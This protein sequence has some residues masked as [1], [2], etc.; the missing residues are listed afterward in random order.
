MRSLLALVFAFIPT[1]VSAADSPAVHG[2]LLFG[3]KQQY[4]SHL[5]MFHKPHDYQAVF[6][7]DLSHA[8]EY[9]ADKAAHP[10][11]IYTVVPTPFSLPDMAQK[12]GGFRAQLVRGHFERGG[13]TIVSCVVIYLKKAI[14][15]NHLD[16]SATAPKHPEYLVF[17]KGG[18]NFA[19]HLIHGAPDFDQILSVTAAPGKVTL[20]D[21]AFDK[22]VDAGE[23]EVVGL[24]KVQSLYLELDDLRK[25]H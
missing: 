12:L 19:A 5:P 3:E 11:E 8:K 4:L 21:R 1:F 18:E 24:G 25:I 9:L 2:M 10:G 16:E 7:I 14:V 13:K 15:F 23:S 6:E 22:P 17:G 20:T